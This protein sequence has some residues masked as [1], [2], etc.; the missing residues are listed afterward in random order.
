MEIPGY[1]VVDGLFGLEEL[2]IMGDGWDGMRRDVRL[3]EAN[4]IQIL[5]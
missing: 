3:I 2:L 1:L 4:D 5:L